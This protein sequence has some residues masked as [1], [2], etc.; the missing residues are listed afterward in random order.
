MQRD[1]IKLL[2]ETA[3]RSGFEAVLDLTLTSTFISYINSSS[4][5]FLIS[6]MRTKLAHVILVLE[7]NE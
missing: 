1:L 7:T 6:K 5:S 4:L 3:K 2:S